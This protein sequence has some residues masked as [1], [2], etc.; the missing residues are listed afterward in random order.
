MASIIIG[1]LVLL[2]LEGLVNAHGDIGG[3]LI[4]SDEDRAGV[5][6]E[7]GLPRSS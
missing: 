1:H 7:A 6:V 2:C 5:S 4:Q 3:L